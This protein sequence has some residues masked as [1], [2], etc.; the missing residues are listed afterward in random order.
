MWSGRSAVKGV[1]I[2]RS[3]V[4]SRVR[5]SSPFPL[6]GKTDRGKGGENT[7]E[8]NVSYGPRE[9]TQSKRKRS[10]LGDS[11]RSIRRSRN[12]KPGLTEIVSPKQ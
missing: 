4:S 6:K 8:R 7:K 11:R 12:V 1:P 5:F 3:F 10:V 9:V 2:L